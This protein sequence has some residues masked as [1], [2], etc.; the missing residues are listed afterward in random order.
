MS[1]IVILGGGECGVRAAFTAREHGY[2]SPITIV[3]EEIGL[4]YERPP[5]SKPD[6]N[7]GTE[8]TICSAEKFADKDITLLQ[9]TEAIGLNRTTR[10]I[11]LST[12]AELQYDKL[13]FA[14]GAVPRKLTCLGGERAMTFRTASDATAIYAKAQQG[15]HVVIVG[16]GLIGL[17]LAAV[18]IGRGVHVTVL[19][20]APFPLG[21]NVPQPLAKRIVDRHITEGVSIHC[22]AEVKHITD[23]HVD[24]VDGRSIP[25]DLVV[26]AVGVQARTDLAEV[27]GL[28]TN[29]GICVNEMLRTSSPHIFAAGDC[30]NVSMNG[31]AGQRFETWQ[32]AQ[33]QGDIAGRNMTGDMAVLADPVWFWSDQ[34]DLGLQ[35]VGQTSEAPAAVRTGTDGSEVLFYLDSAGKL[36]GAAGLGIGNAVAKDIKLAQKLIE[37]S[38]TVDAELLGDSNTNLKKLL[39][40]A[41]A[42]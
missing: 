20:Y 39:R 23:T 7:G 3:S 11:V 37:A 13:L 15:A 22:N 19:E 33:N 16:A 17:E 34:F 18:L 14:T 1:G 5:L 32:N 6:E 38:V 25:S 28:E 9:A 21:R 26:A 24:L 36:A 12:G 30:A 35:A 2:L 8:K 27:S 41:P 4:P 40:P 31:A 10:Q 42:L 29:N